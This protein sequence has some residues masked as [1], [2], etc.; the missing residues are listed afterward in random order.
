[1]TS[2]LSP[3]CRPQIYCGDFLVWPSSLGQGVGE[4]MCQ[5]LRRGSSQDQVLL[6]QGE[7]LDPSVARW[8]TPSSDK[9]PEYLSDLKYHS[10]QQLSW[11][12]PSFTDWE[13]TK[14]NTP[15]RVVITK[16][17]R[18]AVPAFLRARPYSSSLY[19]FMIHG[20]WL[21]ENSGQ[22]LRRLHWLERCSNK[23][24]WSLLP[25]GPDRDFAA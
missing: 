9:R 12:L 23:H 19:C 4:E 15:P 17:T 25:N 11:M 6:Q 10:H 14:H 22:T 1:M 2:H 21:T 16:A 20:L 18:V 5:V 8:M 13:K 24:T 7:L 3:L